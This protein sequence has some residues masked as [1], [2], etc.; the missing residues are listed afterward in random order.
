M[1]STAGDSSLC[2]AIDFNAHASHLER[3][4][5]RREKIQINWY[6]TKSNHK[7]STPSNVMHAWR[8]QLQQ[9]VDFEIYKRRWRRRSSAQWKFF[10]CQQIPRW[11][12][13]VTGN[14]K[15]K[16]QIAMEMNYA[17]FGHVYPFSMANHQPH[18]YALLLLR[19]KH[20]C[21][22]RRRCCMPT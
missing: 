6:D 12:V 7:I 13:V 5:K 10:K 15:D 8:R 1:N 4:K 21:P 19:N 9:V 17:M 2:S 22:M 14:C 16:L 3:V 11:H 20:R 18:N